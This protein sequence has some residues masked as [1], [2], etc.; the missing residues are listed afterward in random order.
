MGETLVLEDILRNIKTEKE[1]ENFIKK[2]IKGAT[3]EFH[4]FFEEYL[5]SQKIEKS[6]VIAKSGVN[7]NYGYNILNGKRKRPSRDKVIALCIGANMDYD[8]FIECL[9]I[10]EVGDINPRSKRDIWIVM[11]INTKMGN[12]VRLNLILEEKGL[13]PLNV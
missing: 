5:S 3:L 4:I 2:Y 1:C 10:A 8:Q 12:V 7:K 11:A 13:A 6:E 9:R